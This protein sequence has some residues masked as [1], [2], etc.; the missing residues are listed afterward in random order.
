MGAFGTGIFADDEALDVRSEYYAG[1]LADAQ[2]DAVATDAIMRQYSA[3]WDDPASNTGFWLGLALTQWK[4]GRLDPRV[5][6]ASFRILDE[7]LDL[8]KW[9]GSPAADR[10]KRERALEQTRQ[11]LESPQ[12]PAKAMP[13]PLPMQLP[14]W[15]FGEVVGVRTGQEQRIA[16]L[17]VTGY[18]TSSLYRAKAPVV[19]ILNWTIASLPGVPEEVDALTYIDWRGIQFGNHLYV[20]AAKPPLDAARFVHTGFSKPVTRGEAATGYRSIRKGETLDDVLADVLRP[21][22]ANPA[23]EPHH[24]VV[25]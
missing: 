16:L 23:L 7:G 25:R 2:S 17:H 24:P 22:W 18:K 9:E 5:R 11:T 1:F 15:E 12:P 19:S 21:Y 14:G 20:L 6:T 13:K 3:S 10:R 8:R 4:L